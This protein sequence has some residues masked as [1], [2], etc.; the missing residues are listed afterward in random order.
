MPQ[1]DMACPTPP[2]SQTTVFAKVIVNPE[3]GGVFDTLFLF[4]Q[5]FKHA[6]NL[7]GENTC[8]LSGCTN[9]G[10]YRRSRMH[11]HDDWISAEGAQHLSMLSLA[12]AKQNVQAVHGLAQTSVS[13]RSECVAIHNYPFP[14]QGLLALHAS[15][16]KVNHL[17]HG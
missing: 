6:L 3:V 8:Q 11:T 4:Q 9:V 14:A 2:L 13:A 1:N 10:R 16:E 17:S 15:L 7:W 12:V 5:A